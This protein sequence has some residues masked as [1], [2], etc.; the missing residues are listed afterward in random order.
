MRRWTR[1]EIR[2]LRCGRCQKPFSVG[3]PM[4]LVGAAELRRCA[5]CAGPA[6]ANLAPLYHAP[7]DPDAKQPTTRRGNSAL[8]FDGKAAA[9]GE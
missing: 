3:D 5:D 1:V 9:A 7:R 6:P 2:R 4:C 8:R